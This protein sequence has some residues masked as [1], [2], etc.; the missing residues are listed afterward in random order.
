MTYFNAD[1]GEAEMCGNG[2]RCSVSFAHT[3][4]LCWTKCRFDTRAGSS[5]GACTGPRTSRSA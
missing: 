2:A 5:K 3:R 1:G 4:G